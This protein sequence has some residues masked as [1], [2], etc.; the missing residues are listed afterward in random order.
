MG[1]YAIYAL[2]T[3]AMQVMHGMY[4]RDVCMLWDSRT[5]IGTCLGWMSVGFVGDWSRVG[6]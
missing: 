4:E 5:F 2:A 1:E 3:V 6:T